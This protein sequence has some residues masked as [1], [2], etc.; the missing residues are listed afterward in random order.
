ME[1]E[2]EFHAFLTGLESGLEVI[3]Q[4]LSDLRQ[5]IGRRDDR[6]LLLFE[7]AL[8]EIGGNVLTHGRPVGTGHQIEYVLAYDGETIEATFTDSGPAAHEHLSR[9]MPG[10]ESED[11]RGLV[12]A[13]TVLDELGYEREGNLNRWRLVK[14]L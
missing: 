10:H 2:F 9:E 6:A 11:G 8:G 12:L 7:I 4:S 1:E 13:R 14:R 3:H 5:E